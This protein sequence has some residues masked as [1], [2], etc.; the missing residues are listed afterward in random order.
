MSEFD[1]IFKSLDSDD[2][3]TIVRLN[4][5]DITEIILYDD[6]IKCIDKVTN[7]DIVKKQ[8]KQEGVTWK[9][10]ELTILRDV[11]AP[12]KVDGKDIVVKYTQIFLPSKYVYDG[13]KLRP[14]YN[15]SE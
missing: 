1:S 8:C 3:K 10:T 7:E 11:K 2:Q 5:Y 14:E 15:P 4:K 12:A 13:N 9:R 6:G